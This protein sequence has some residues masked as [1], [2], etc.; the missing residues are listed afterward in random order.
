[1]HQLGFLVSIVP[2]VDGYVGRGFI[3][4]RSIFNSCGSRVILPT[5][6]DSGFHSADVY[7]DTGRFLKESLTLPILNSKHGTRYKITLKNFSSIP[8]WV[9]LVGDNNKTDTHTINPQQELVITSP[10]VSLQNLFIQSQVYV[11]DLLDHNGDTR[12]LGTS[13][14]F[15][16]TT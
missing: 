16:S 7:E 4:T 11:P 13:L 10:Q 1:M 14:L 15:L 2:G 9:K 5:E 12:S 8:L 6:F 3:A